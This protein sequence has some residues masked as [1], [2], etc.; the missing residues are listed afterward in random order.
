MEINGL[1]LPESFVGDI[2]SGRFRRVRGCWDLKKDFDAYGN[3]LETEI[4]E[5]CQT[6]EAL[7]SET[8]LYGNTLLMRA[9]TMSQ[10]NGRM[11]QVIFATLKITQK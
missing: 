7:L 2:Q 8:E 5:V 6:K 10:T 9:Q 11:S 3:P 4:G 1:T